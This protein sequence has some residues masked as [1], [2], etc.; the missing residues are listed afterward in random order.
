MVNQ[1]WF[2]QFIDDVQG[3]DR[4]VE[5]LNAPPRQGPGEA[6]VN[7]LLLGGGWGVLFLMPGSLGSGIQQTWTCRDFADTD[8][9]LAYLNQDPRL[10]PGEVG[11]G[12]G[13]TFYLVP[14]TG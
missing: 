11:G 1:T 9:L 10:G 3:P 7:P 12:G 4:V 2:F 8:S 5:F 6:I 14:G 13:T